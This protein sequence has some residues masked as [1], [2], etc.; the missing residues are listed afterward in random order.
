MSN[1][2]FGSVSTISLLYVV[3]F[4]KH[5]FFF[6]SKKFSCESDTVTRVQ[7][8]ILLIILLNERLKF[9]SNN[10]AGPVTSSSNENFPRVVSFVW[11]EGY[12][13]GV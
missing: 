9:F 3:A 4:T 10:Y 2:C 7:V 1:H 8:T 5:K 11:G 12:C 6:I 13:M